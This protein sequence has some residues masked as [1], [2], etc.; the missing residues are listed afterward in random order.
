MSQETNREREQNLGREKY[1]LSDHRFCVVQNPHPDLRQAIS[2]NLN[3]I[4]CRMGTVTVIPQETAVRVKGRNMGK[5][6]ST[7]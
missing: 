1:M 5:A 6:L 3:G 7:Q 2:L 4:N